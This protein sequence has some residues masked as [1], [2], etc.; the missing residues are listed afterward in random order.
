MRLDPSSQDVVLRDLHKF[1]TY[2][3]TVAGF[4]R[5]GSGPASRVYITT[6]EDGKKTRI[7]SIPARGP[8]VA[9][10]FSTT[11]VKISHLVNKLCSQQACNKLVNKL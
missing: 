5:I 4:S 9:R 1:S 3:V 10:Y 2:E 11:H 6:D 8:V 7:G